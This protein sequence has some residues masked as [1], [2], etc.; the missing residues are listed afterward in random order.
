MG[1]EAE[2]EDAIKSYESMEI[3]TPEKVKEQMKEEQ[4]ALQKMKN[5]AMD[6]MNMTQEEREEKMKKDLEKLMEEAQAEYE[7]EQKKLKAADMERLGYTDEDK[8]DAYVEEENKKA[9]EESR[10]MME[11]MT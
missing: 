1:I 4:E 9:M 5:E 6:L 10:K 11:E 3:L 8:Y 7:A 2:Y